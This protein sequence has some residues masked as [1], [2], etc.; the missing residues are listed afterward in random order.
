MSYSFDGVD[1]ILTDNTNGGTDLSIDVYSFMAWAKVGTLPSSTG[2]I[3]GRASG[4]HSSNHMMMRVPGSETDSSQDWLRQGGPTSGV[5]GAG[6][7]S[8]DGLQH[9][10]GG[11]AWDHLLGTFDVNRSQRFEAYI[12]GGGAFTYGDSGDAATVYENHDFSVGQVYNDSARIYEG[13][14]AHLCIW[15]RVLTAQEITDLANGGDP[16]TVAPSGLIRYW[17]LQSDSATQV[18]QAGSGHDLTVY[19]ASYST[20]EPPVT[21]TTTVKPVVTSPGKTA[22][23]IDLAWTIDGV[24]DS[25]E[26]RRGGVIIDTVTGLSYTD[27]GLT[28]GA[29]YTY[30]VRAARA[31]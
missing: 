18:D 4:T 24:W 15:N 28:P 1:D 17:P 11:T 13:L 25:Y 31:V 2:H 20:D 16:E 21:T 6:W 12:N 23:T 29:E 3:M 27:T 19:G 22:T 26:I 14:L 8:Q 9:S 30:E 7:S 5:N 10:V